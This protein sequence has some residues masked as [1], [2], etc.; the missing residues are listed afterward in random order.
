ML[1]IQSQPSGPR[2]PLL[3]S[4]CQEGGKEGKRR[5]T[6]GGWAVVVSDHTQPWLP[7]RATM[8]L[9]SAQVHW[10]ERVVSGVG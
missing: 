4:E 2:C 1:F 9:A 6:L 3:S 5:A 8:R 7:I 10:E